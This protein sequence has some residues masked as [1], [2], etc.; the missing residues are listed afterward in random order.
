MDI[1][2]WGVFMALKHADKFRGDAKFSTWF[3]QIIK[4][5]CMNTIRRRAVRK[6]VPLEVD[7]GYVPAASPAFLLSVL[8]KGLQKEEQDLLEFRA[9]GLGFEEIADK[10]GISVVYARRKWSRLRR[11]LEAVYGM[12]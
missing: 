3:H 4:N 8:K 2:N 7:V 9:A 6:E 11:K 12:G 1:V 5:L 10:L